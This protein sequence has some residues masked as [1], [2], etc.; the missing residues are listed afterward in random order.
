MQDM[1]T[2]YTTTCDMTKALLCAL[3]EGALQGGLKLKYF[4]LSVLTK[5]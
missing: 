3:R 2:G 5:T 4:E 1:T